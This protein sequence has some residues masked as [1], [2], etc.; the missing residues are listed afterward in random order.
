MILNLKLWQILV[1]NILVISDV[2]NYFK[3][4]SKYVKNSKIHIINF[5]KDGAGVYTYDENY[6]LFQNYKVTDQVKEIEKNKENFD[7]AVVM[8]AGERIAYLA[9]L[10]YISYY[11]GRDID[12]PRFIKNSR[13]PWYKEPLHKLN[14]LERTF[15]KKTFN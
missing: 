10:N 13:E 12:A 2:G 5:P 1:L 3:T 7:L 15:Y 6:K 14:F 4:V 8:G 11:V 9:D